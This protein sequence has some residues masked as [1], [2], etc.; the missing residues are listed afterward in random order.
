MSAQSEEVRRRKALSRCLSSS[1]NYIYILAAKAIN[2][3]C[4]NS[5]LKI[6]FYNMALKSVFVRAIIAVMK[7]KD[8]KQVGEERVYFAYDFMALF[9][10]EGS[11]GRNSNGAE[12][13]KQELKY[14]LWRSA[15]YFTGLLLSAFRIEPPALGGTTHSGLDCPMSVTG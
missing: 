12:T 11:Q 1:P 9:I 3:H 2:G 4:K 14:K 8:Q 7:H 13:W 10:P 15:A 6:E 5:S